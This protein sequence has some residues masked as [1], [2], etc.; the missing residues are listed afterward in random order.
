MFRKIILCCLLPIVAVAQPAVLTLEDVVALARE[1]SIAAKQTRTQQKTSYW[2]YRSFL[3]D[4]K[5]QLSLDGYVPSFTRS[6]TQVTQPDGTINFVPISNNNS[7]VNLS[8]SQNI[9]L[10]GGSVFVQKQLQRFD[11]FQRNNTLYNGIPFAV[12]IQQPLFRFNSMK[13][14]RRIEPIRFEESNQQ[15]IEGLEQV[16]VNATSLY[17]DLLVAQV[18][19]QIAEKNRSNNDTLYKIAQEKMKLGKLSQNDLL[20]L[21]LGLLTAQKDLASARQTAEVTTLKLKTYMGYRSEGSG[22]AGGLTLAIPAQLTEFPVDL[23]TALKQGF[24]NRSAAIGFRRR[25]LEA[26]RD[27]DKARRDNGLNATLNAAFGLSNRGQ[28]PTDI[29]RQP[30]DREFLEIQFTLPIQK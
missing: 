18:N 7:L 3:A 21:Q 25:Q 8:L 24:A 27:L 15:A 22:T 10:T 2:K 30:Q 29:Y 9:P 6:Y 19:L 13:W 23:A 28:R 5:P 16:S 11:D 17:F 26:E 12:G 1:Q 4:Y 14:D 20:Q